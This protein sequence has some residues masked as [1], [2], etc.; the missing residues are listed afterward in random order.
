MTKGPCQLES[1]QARGSVGCCQSP[2]RTA[3]LTRSP[4]LTE[5]PPG[6]YPLGQNW[7]WTSL[8]ASTW[9]VVPNDFALENEISFGKS[10]VALERIWTGTGPEPRR[11]QV[12]K[13]SGEEVTKRVDPFR[14]GG[15]LHCL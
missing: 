7:T 8:W 10:E 4:V 5:G 12:M 1:R 2:S 11:G 6:L 13:G 3:C 9:I 14:G 15:P